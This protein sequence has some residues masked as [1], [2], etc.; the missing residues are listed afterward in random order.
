MESH[1]EAHD[2][3]DTASAVLLRGN[4][5]GKRQRT[6][7]RHGRSLGRIR[8]AQ[9]ITWRCEHQHIV[10]E[11]YRAPSAAVHVKVTLPLSTSA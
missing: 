5:R 3:T 2:S 11:D 4:Q 8:K 10:K 6:G 1:S 7:N 9:E